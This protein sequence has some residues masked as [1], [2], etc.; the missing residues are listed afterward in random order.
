MQKENWHFDW[1]E[2]LDNMQGRNPQALVQ[3]WQDTS[4]EFKTRWALIS[5]V[6]TDLNYGKHPREKYDIFKPQGYCRGTVVF[7]H[8][9]YWM[10]TGRE[11]WSF[12][13][14]GILQHGWAVAIPSYPL[15]PEV[16]ISAIT[17]CMTKAVEYIAAQTSGELRLIGHSAGGHLVSRLISKDVLGKEVL[18]RIEK[19]I[20]VSGLYDLRP[21][22]YTKMN[23]TLNLT[24]AEAIE[25]SSIF[26]CPENVNFTCWVGGHERPEF[27]RQNRL[28]QEAWSGQTTPINQIEAI[29]DKGH[30]HFTV[31][32][33][34]ADL[35]SPLT[36]IITT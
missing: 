24:I 27:L 35:N 30:D 1:D 25:E 31:I 33:Q 19:I 18:S 32:E 11:C 20:S 9:G 6:T 36:Q 14:E 2:A 12:L 7:I 29:Y 17:S 21:L 26:L 5:D 13:A 4:D 22:L 10:R 3:S 15:A 23:E 16:S 8:G 28:L 34:L